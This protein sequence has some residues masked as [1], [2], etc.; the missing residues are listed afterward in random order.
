VRESLK[1]REVLLSAAPHIIWPLRFVLPYHTGLRASWLIRTGLFLYD[2]I[3][4]RKILPGTRQGRPYEGRGRPSAEARIPRGLRIFR[5]LGRGFAPGSA[6]R[7]RRSGS[8]R[9]G[10]NRH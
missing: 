5:L 7:D 4:G 2:N 10:R 8:G 3:G 6:E 9:G 1:E